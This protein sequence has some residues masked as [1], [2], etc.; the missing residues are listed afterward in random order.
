MAW[1]YKWTGSYWSL[2]SYDS[3]NVLDNATEVYNQMIASGWTHEASI[4]AIANL[5]YESTGINAGQWEGRTP[6]TY[7]GNN[8]GFGIAQWTPWTK[9]RDFVGGQS[10]DKMMDGSAQVRMLLSQSSQWGTSYLSPSGYSSKYD[11][12]APYYST[13]ADYSQGTS[14]VE[15]MTTAYMIC[16]EKPAFSYGHS[17]ITERQKY[18]RYFDEQLGGSGGKHYVTVQVEGN[19]SAYASPTSGE[20]GTVIQLHQ[21]AYDDSEFVEWIVVSGDVTIEDDTFTLGSTNVVI[22]AVF[23][24]DTPVPTESYTVTIIV[25]GKG[26]AYA[27]PN[28]AQEGDTIHLYAEKTGN[29]KFSK[30]TSKDV[31]IIDATK[32]IASFTMPSK[33]VTIYA[34]FNTSMPVW[35]MLRPEWTMH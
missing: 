11:L 6:Q 15:D 10:Q 30:F 33:D 19:G 1:H 28:I 21:S 4:G 13:F 22:K 35:M 23:T 16:W 26:S 32:Q 20:D 2:G 14:S 34:W 29:N 27:M 31:T 9:V 18:A 17:S 8:Q 7:Y 24:G 12:Y 5:C 25:K 3:Q